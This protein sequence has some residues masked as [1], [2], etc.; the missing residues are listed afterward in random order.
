MDQQERQALIARQLKDIVSQADNILKGNDSNEAIEG[1]SKYSGE[2]KKYLKEDSSNDMI[3][4]RLAQLPFIDY[5]QLDA[6]ATSTILGS[7]LFGAVITLR[8]YNKKKKILADI[9][10]AQGLYSSIEF[11]YRS[12]MT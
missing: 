1:F 11:L 12:E 3:L 4:E 2:L 7:S 5:K 8:N 10:T 9:R 6:T